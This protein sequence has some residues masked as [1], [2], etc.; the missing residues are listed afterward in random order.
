MTT[1]IKRTPATKRTKSTVVANGHSHGTM[2]NGSSLT[3]P[4]EQTELPVFP[5][6]VG[7]RLVC[8]PQTGEWTEAPLTLLDL[9]FPTDDDVGVVK[10]SQSPMHD[11]LTNLITTMLRMYLP[12]PEWLITNDVLIHWGRKGVPPKSPDVAVISG[13]RRPKRREKSY[14]IGRDGPRPAFVVE[15]TSAE[16]L[17]NDLITK[18]LFYAAIGIQEYLIIDLLAKESTDWQLSGYR[19]GTSP[20]YEEITPDADGGITFTSIGIRFLATGQRRL[21]LYDATTSERLLTPDE[22]RTQA[23][24]QQTRAEAEKARAE[25]EKARAEAEKAR[26]DQYEVLLKKAGLL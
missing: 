17:E 10:V 14:R 5:I 1:K 15:V 6:D 13:G 7:Y 3:A 4:D 8:D 11:I 9:L 23:K 2:P 22:Q 25:A 26:A 21:D 19:L 12:E 24:T 20:F 18:K 16:T